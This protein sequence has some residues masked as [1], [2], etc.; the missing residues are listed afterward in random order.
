MTQ[1]LNPAQ[2]LFESSSSNETGCLQF[3]GESVSWRVYLQ[4]G[5]LKYADCSIQLM[6][7]LKYYLLRQGCK[8]AAAALKD[9]PP[10]YLK[11]QAK[12]EQNSSGR[13]LYQ[14][15]LLWLLKEKHI[16]RLQLSQLLE[17]ITQDSLEF[18]FWLTEGNFNWNRDESNPAW[19]REQI[20]ESLSLDIADL[21]NF[22]KQRLTKWQNCASSLLS[23]H[24]RPYILD[25]RDINKSPSSG[26]LSQ[27]ALNEL[28]QMMR[29]GLS[30]RQLS[31]VLNR[32]ELHIAQILSPYI[33]KKVIHLRNPQSP[34]D[35]LPDIPRLLAKEKL[36]QASKTFKIACI[37]DS[38]TIL[39]EMQRF[40]EE[41]RF[42]VT[43]IDD[44]VQA[45]AVIFRL[46]PDLVLMDI[47]MPRIN[48]YKLCSLLRSSNVFKETPIVMVTGNT[49]MIDKARA[50]M[51]G[52]TDYLTKPFTQEGLMNIVNKY[53]QQI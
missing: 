8:A 17:E 1:K 45:S 16:D 28:A 38:P 34:L 14:Q 18:C 46:E 32:D 21:I 7:E 40:L 24:Q 36:S 19:I 31:I 30:F 48:G 9:M 44:P 53:L 35:K 41:D 22:L 29:R 39:N 12:M 49:G 27:Q 43:A 11:T 47:T 4:A 3:N 52:A 51:A 5:K 23:P 37:D 25:Y 6:A 15:T 10:L 33:E 42:E 26:T 13:S 20:G 50:K 2:L